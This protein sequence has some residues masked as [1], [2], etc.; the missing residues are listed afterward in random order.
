M[1]NRT[2]LIVRH[3]PDRQFEDRLISYKIE[4][5]RGS[6]YSGSEVADSTLTEPSLC[7]IGILGI[8]SLLYFELS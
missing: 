4:F 2:P 6:F 7:F 8:D 3:M 1:F 5:E